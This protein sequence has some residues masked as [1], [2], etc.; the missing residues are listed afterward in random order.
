M[1][2]WSVE[3][4]M[5]GA[6]EVEAET[7]DE[8]ARLV[9]SALIRCEGRGLFYEVEVCTVSTPSVVPAEDVR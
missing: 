4:D 1:K 6:I 7:A 2:E 8:A 3:F 5:N 9:R